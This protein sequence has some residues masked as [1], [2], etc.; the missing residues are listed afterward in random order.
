MSLALL[1]QLNLEDSEPPA[2]TPGNVLVYT[3]SRAIGSAETI[4]LDYVQPGDGVE[5]GVGNDVESFSGFSVVNNST[6]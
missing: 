6:Q 2:P 5:D 1:F 4:T 3:I